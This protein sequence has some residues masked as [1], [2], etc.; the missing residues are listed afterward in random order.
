[1]CSRPKVGEIRESLMKLDNTMKR[2]DI[3]TS[4]RATAFR[5]LMHEVPTR[6]YLTGLS[7]AEIEPREAGF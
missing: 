6:T 1:M 5:P 2:L 7:S 3:S 4:S